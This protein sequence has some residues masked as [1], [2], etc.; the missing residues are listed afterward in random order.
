[1]IKNKQILLIVLLVFIN[2]YGIIQ[3]AQDCIVTKDV[4]NTSA[5]DCDTSGNLK[6][7]I[8]QVVYNLKTSFK[9]PNDNCIPGDLRNILKDRLCSRKSIDLFCSKTEKVL[10]GTKT[11]WDPC[12]KRRIVVYIYKQREG[13][14]AGSNQIQINPDLLDKDPD[15]IEMTLYHELIHVAENYYGEQQLNARDVSEEDFTYTCTKK[16]YNSGN[17][18]AKEYPQYKE[19]PTDASKCIPCEQ[20]RLPNAPGSN[21][22]N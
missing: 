18:T 8:K 17:C 19:C 4:F 21:N 10:I 1:M 20:Y 14:A 5:V 11:K 7:A 3:M 9:N 13:A 16:Y 2:S 12:H 22:Q 15:T 6:T